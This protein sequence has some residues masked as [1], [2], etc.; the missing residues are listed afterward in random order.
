[1]KLTNFKK[2]LEQFP[3]D[4]VPKT[5]STITLCGTTDEILKWTIANA[6]ILKLLW[7]YELTNLFIGRCCWFEPT[8]C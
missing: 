5:I 7:G 8:H 2:D 6:V 3:D 4:L 1:M